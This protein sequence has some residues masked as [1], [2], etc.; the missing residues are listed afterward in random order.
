MNPADLHP[1]DP[2]DTIGERSD[3]RGGMS[4]A[5]QRDCEMA[6]ATTHESHSEISA[7]SGVYRH[8]HAQRRGDICLRLRDAHSS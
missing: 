5:Q 7:F 8:D 2:D 6:G 3:R 4:I 1:R